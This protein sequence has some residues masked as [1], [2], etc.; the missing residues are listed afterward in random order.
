MRDRENA[1][2]LTH[3]EYM[4]AALDGGQLS[5]P[6]TAHDGTFGG[7]CLNCGWEPREVAIGRKEGA[8]A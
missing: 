4:T 2:G 5:R 6:C 3:F 8:K 7:R 1:D